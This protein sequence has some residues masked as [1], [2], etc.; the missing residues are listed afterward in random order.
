MNLFS[1]PVYKGHLD[2][3]FNI[4]DL[5]SGLSK[6][7]W[8]GETGYTTA[9]SDLMLWESVPEVEDLIGAMFPYVAKY[10][11][12]Q[13][14]YDKCELRPS[15]AWANWHEPGDF[16]AEHSHA[17][18]ARQTHVAS[19][20][21]MEKQEGGDIELINPL[22]YIHRLTPLSLDRSPGDMLM[23]ESISCVTGDFL[24]FPGWMRHRTQPATTTRKAISIN[25]NGYL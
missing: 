6:G 12:E 14:G 20:F 15:S 5:W 11:D 3:S 8:S 1:I 23:S 24:L 2:Q 18:G 21:Y 9:Q 13:L 25:F 10:W 19:V 17:A 22:D 4:P 16:T 7:V